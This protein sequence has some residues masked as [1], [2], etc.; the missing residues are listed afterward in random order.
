MV[1][2]QQCLKQV[3]LFR[4]MGSLPLMRTS[5]RT[6]LHIRPTRPTAM[7]SQAPSL[8]S[9]N[10]LN[11]HDYSSR[12]EVTVIKTFCFGSVFTQELCTFTM[13]APRK[14]NMGFLGLF[15]TKEIVSQLIGLLI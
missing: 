1:Q 14:Y 13:V 10:Y 4:F 9:S 5:T 6:L 11:E 8:V 2:S 7:C 15:S 12:G 3:L